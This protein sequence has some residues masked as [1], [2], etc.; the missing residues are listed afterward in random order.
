MALW[1]VVAL[2]TAAAILA[3]VW[4]LARANRS[5]R[6]GSD[7]AVYKDQLEEIQRD[8][9]AGLIGESEAEAAQVEVSRRLLAAADAE[10]ALAPAVPTGATG[11]RRRVGVIAALVISLGSASI[12]LTLGSPTLPGQPLASREKT[13]PIDAML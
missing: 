10:A 6:S 4:P 3:V 1:F 2:M 9:I 8:R 7:V 5:L 13:P 11:L 12:Y